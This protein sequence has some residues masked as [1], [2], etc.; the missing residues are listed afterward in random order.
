MFFTDKVI[1]DNHYCGYDAFT[2]ELSCIQNLYHNNQ[3]KIINQHSSSPGDEK[4]DEFLCKP[5]KT[6]CMALEYQIF[7]TDISSQLDNNQG[8]KIG[9]AVVH[10]YVYKELE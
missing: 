1:H 6:P 5:P 10:F 2:N 3:S 8:E 9:L 4:A 7:I